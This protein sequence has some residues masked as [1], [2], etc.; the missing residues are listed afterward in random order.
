MPRLSSLAVVVVAAAI[1]AAAAENDP[2]LGFGLN[3]PTMS[4]SSGT[5]AFQPG[6][7][8]LSYS[9]VQLH[10]MR[11]LGFTSIRLPINIA[12]ANDPRSLQT[13]LGLVQAIG[14]S[15]VI[16]MFG[17]GSL[18]AHGTGRVDNLPAA[19]GAW[20]KVHAT[21][22]S[23]PDV[24]YEIFNEPHGYTVGCNSPPC[25]TGASYLSDMRAVIAGAK[26]P[27]DRCVLDSLGWAG[28]AHGL[29]KL[30]WTGLIGYHFYP[31]W[32][33]ANSTRKEFSSFFEL[34]LAGISDRVLVTEFG[35]SLDAAN[36]NYEEPTT[37][38][39]NVNCLQGMD[40]AVKAF[41]ERG[42]G[43]Q[44]AYHWHG[45]LDGDSFSFFEPM[46]INGSTKVLRILKDCC[47]NSSNNHR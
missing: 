4:G 20:S 15:A 37:T 42:A 1:A 36:T 44:G 24:K 12:T 19:I 7:Y 28:D 27:H 29:V 18:I 23:L 33:P 11:L 46:N 40:D 5:G 26:L 8:N 22:G 2:F 25:G 14:G 43:I 34:Q 41:R 16:C 17:T 3:L 45:W 47:A 30:G 9:S 10:R 6:V 35:G 32:L 13:I 38:D 31:W 21:L 39:N